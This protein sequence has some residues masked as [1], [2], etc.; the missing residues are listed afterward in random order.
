MFE[1]L[2]RVLKA[3]VAWTREA[4][5]FDISMSQSGEVDMEGILLEPG[6]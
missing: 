1:A 3:I 5:G 6:R 4:R 2:G